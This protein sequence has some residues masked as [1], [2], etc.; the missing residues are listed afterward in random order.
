M[1]TRAHAPLVTGPSC[2][3]SPDVCPRRAR[4]TER[5][6]E[7]V[8]R[9]RA[10]LRR[11]PGSRGAAGPPP[12]RRRPQ[13]ALSLRQEPRGVQGLDVI[14]TTSR[15]APRALPPPEPRLLGRHKRLPSWKVLLSWPG[16]RLAGRRP[17]AA[18]GGPGSVRRAVT[19]GSRCPTARRRG[20]RPH[21]DPSG[22][23][24][25]AT[26]RR[27]G[28]QRGRS[29]SPGRGC[30]EG[31]GPRSPGRCR[32]CGGPVPVDARAAASAGEGAEGGRAALSLTRR[33]ARQC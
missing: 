31:S 21:P 27:A 28:R 9:D 2:V 7:S 30:A 16:A 11:S 10:L 15:W 19:L 1:Y 18:R 24:P 23:G 5:V 33:R 3:R 4:H 20:D 8:R 29:C 13:S 32:A 17:P 22:S 12:G 14:K 26:Q 25:S 6:P